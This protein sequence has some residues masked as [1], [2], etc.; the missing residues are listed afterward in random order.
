MDT[1]NYFLTKAKLKELKK[2]YEELVV[3]ERKK[4]ME[5]EAPKIFESEN[6]NPDFVNFQDD[7]NFLRGRID[8]LKSVFE[9]HT[10]IKKPSKD[11]KNIVGLGAKVKIEVDGQK[12]E[13][14]IV[15]T[16]E[17][18]PVLGRISNESPVGAAL[19]GCKVGDEITVP[20]PV[21]TIYKIK[22]I[23]YEIS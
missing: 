10:L 20:S 23:K 13:F 12:D 11:Q 1:K 21:K 17:A 15:G 19:L 7:L 4:S 16:L 14:M 2:E 8:E 3:L 5:S 9:N 22:S 18:N 6:L